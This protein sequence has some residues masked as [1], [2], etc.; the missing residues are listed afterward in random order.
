MV[1]QFTQPQMSAPPQTQLPALSPAQWA[2]ISQQ[3]SQ[4]QPQGQAQTAPQ[5][6]AY[7][8][9][10]TMSAIDPAL[11]YQQ[12]AQYQASQLPTSSVIPQYAPAPQYAPPQ[13]Q[14]D[15][16]S[17]DTINALTQF[18]GDANIAAQDAANYINYLEQL[19]SQI[20]D[21]YRELIQFSAAQD[22]LIEKFLFN[23]DF[24]LQYARYA[25]VQN[26][27]S[28][29]F[30]SDLAD[31][32]LEIAALSPYQQSQQQR[33]PEFTGSPVNFSAQLQTQNSIPPLPNSGGNTT[34]G[35]TMEQYLFAQQQGQVAA[36][37]AA[38]LQNPANLYAALFQ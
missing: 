37:R 21:G 12:W 8:S 18:V 13:P 27:V 29:R 23:R 38:A 25:W 5:T 16:I 14:G 33:S 20:G 7:T 1:A 22:A 32:Y 10:G 34:G 36:A 2:Q 11:L 4:S 19:N 6:S 15:F 24:A 35:I 30:A 28:D 26:P 3:L 9:T 31:A 17:N